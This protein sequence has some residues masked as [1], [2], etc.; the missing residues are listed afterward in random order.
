MSPAGA[1]YDLLIPLGY[2]QQAIK[3]LLFIILE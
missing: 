2:N 1:L 3:L